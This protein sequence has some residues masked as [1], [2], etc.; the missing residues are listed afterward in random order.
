[1]EYETFAHVYDEIMDDSLYEK[2]LEFTKSHVQNGQ[3][4]LLEL[5]CGTGILALKLAEQGY[6]VTALDI[7]PDMLA[8]A[9]ERMAEQYPDESL[10]QFIQGDMMALSEVGEN[11][12]IVT[13][14]SDSLCYMNDA[15]EVQ[16]VFDEV[17]RVLDFGGTFIFDVHSDYKIDTL[18][19]NFEFQYETEDYAFLWH[20]EPD[21]APLSVVHEL[22][23]YIRNQDNLFERYLEDHHERTYHLEHYLTMLE[24]AGFD[25]VEVYADFTNEEPTKTSERWFFVATKGA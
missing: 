4:K 21:H 9:S 2:W 8:V 25:R 18:F 11:Y 20:S 13:C 24:S 7:S 23:F 22:S 5:A 17:Y 15:F 19:K 10:V 6:D 3:K 1:M 14:Y 12:E 16:Q